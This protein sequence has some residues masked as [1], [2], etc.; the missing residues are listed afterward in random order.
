MKI[1]FLFFLGFNSKLLMDKLA[2]DEARGLFLD[3]Y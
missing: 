3:S 1:L 2:K